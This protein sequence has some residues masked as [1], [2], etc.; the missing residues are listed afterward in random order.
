MA[1]G[2]I[3]LRSNVVD[4][5][6]AWHLVPGEVLAVRRPDLMKPPNKPTQ[7]QRDEHMY[8]VPCGVCSRTIN[9]IM[10]EGCTQCSHGPTPRQLDNAQEQHRRGLEAVQAARVRLDL[11]GRPNPSDG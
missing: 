4:R 8:Y 3:R 5:G 1:D 9:E 6:D 11:D 10:R 7:L 2:R